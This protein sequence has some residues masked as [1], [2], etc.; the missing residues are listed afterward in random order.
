MALESVDY[1]EEKACKIL[2]IVMQ[3]DKATKDEIQHQ[4]KGDACVD[5]EAA[6]P[7]ANLAA[8]ESPETA[9]AIDHEERYKY[10][11]YYFMFYSNSFLFC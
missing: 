11:F 7:S 6:A 10:L 2:E 4:V 5:N 1:S 9:D 8:H 3:D